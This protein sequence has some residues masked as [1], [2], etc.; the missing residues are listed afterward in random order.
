MA[1]LKQEREWSMRMRAWT[2][3]ALQAIGAATL[4]AY[5]VAGACHAFQGKA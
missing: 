2:Q 4:I 3:I 1:D 5:A